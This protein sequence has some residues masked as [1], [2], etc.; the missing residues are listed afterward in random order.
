MTQGL[1][2]RSKG[3]RCP[4]RCSDL[5]K[6]TQQL[7]IELLIPSLPSS[8]PLCLPSFLYADLWDYRTNPATELPVLK[9]KATRCGI[10]T[11]VFWASRFI[12]APARHVT[13]SGLAPPSCPAF[14]RSH[15]APVI[16]FHQNHLDGTC[17]HPLQPKPPGP[18]D[19][20]GDPW[21]EP[22]RSS[23][24]SGLSGG[25]PAILLGSGCGNPTASSARPS[26]FPIQTLP[27]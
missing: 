1:I 14:T 26:T 9:P 23:G 3:S 2:I 8:L 17:Q 5:P 4:E 10:R 13:P 24:G 19:L 18:S 20:H 7:E 27:P 16:L 11:S 22:V 15:R 12:W 21:A 6:A 25:T